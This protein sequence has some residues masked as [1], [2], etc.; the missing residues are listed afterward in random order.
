VIPFRHVPVNN[1]G[2]LKAFTKIRQEKLAH[3]RHP[4]R[5]SYT[6]KPCGPQLQFG[7]PK[8]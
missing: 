4:V 5:V 6:D 2:L 1:L 7:R 8:A 3:G